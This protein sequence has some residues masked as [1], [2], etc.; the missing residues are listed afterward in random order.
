MFA[1]LRWLVVLRFQFCWFVDSGFLWLLLV[2]FSLVCL[3]C[4]VG[5][6]LFGI[7]FAFG[8]LCFTCCFGLLVVCTQ[9]CCSFLLLWF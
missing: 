1:C 4:F 5:W 8:S 3:F 2:V 7:Y 9:A 6:L